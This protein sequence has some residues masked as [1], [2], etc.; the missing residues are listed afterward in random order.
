M[1]AH[2]TTYPKDNGITGN[3][4]LIL[5]LISAYIKS[6]EK[7]SNHK[8]VNLTYEEI[9]NKLGIPLVTVKRS[10]PELYRN[11]KLFSN[12][13][14]VHN[15]NRLHNIYHFH[16]TYPNVFYISN[17][18]FSPYKLEG[19]KQTDENKLKG[20][21]LLLKRHCLNLTNKYYAKRM[22]KGKVSRSELAKELNMDSGTVGKYIELASKY[23]LIK[24]FDKGLLITDKNIFPDYCKEK[25]HTTR[26]YHLLYDWCI[27]HDI[28]PPDRN[29]ESLLK[30]IASHYGQTKE[31]LMELA[32]M[33][34]MT[35]QDLIA[36]YKLHPHNYTGIFEHYLPYVLSQRV[37]DVTD[38]NL[39]YA[40]KV[41]NIKEP[42]E[43]T[44]GKK[45]YLFIL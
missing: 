25:D 35:G 31:D 26:V 7:Y 1:A 43:E 2:Y 11:D 29:D 30:L 39:R 18:I 19:L 16:A 13:E 5:I 4:K 22:V 14:Q 40:A 3:N 37:K 45:P 17:D 9:S 41:L 8:L 34:N 21:L 38:I 24:E 28:I 42:V 20:F 12:V 10:V 36:D 33:Q 32:R 44:A 6:R 27:Y 23:K 15:G